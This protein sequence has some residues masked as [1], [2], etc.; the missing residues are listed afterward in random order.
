MTFTGI[1]RT[2]STVNEGQY[3]TIG[4]FWDEMTELYG[5]ENIRG[6]GYG[7]TEDTIEYAIG[8]KEGIIEGADFSIELPDEGWI[9]VTGRTDDLPGI[10]SK[11]YED[12]PLLYEIETFTEDGDC[13][14]LFVR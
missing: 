13:E 9:R 3:D 7:W 2:F 10:Y 8:L 6:L 1:N 12:G 5:L 11:I 4:A 14:I